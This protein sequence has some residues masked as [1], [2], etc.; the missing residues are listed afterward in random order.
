MTPPSSG[1]NSPGISPEAGDPLAAAGVLAYYL[2]ILPVPFL[3]AWTPACLA[4]QLRR[5]RERWRRRFRGPGLMACL[6]GSAVVA[7]YAASAFA[8]GVLGSGSAS[9]HTDRIYRAC[10]MGSLVAGLAI[11][12]CWFA[13]GT[14]G[15][16]RPCRQWSDRLG[17]L[18]GVCWTFVGAAGFVSIVLDW[19][20]PV[21]PIGPTARI[22]PQPRNKFLR[23]QAVK[24]S[25]AFQTGGRKRWSRLDDPSRI[26]DA[27]STMGHFRLPI[28]VSAIALGL[29]L[30]FGLAGVAMIVRSSLPGPERTV[31]AA[32]ARLGGGDVGG[33]S[34]RPVL[35][36]RGGQV[37][38]TPSDGE[39]CGTPRA[40][41]AVRR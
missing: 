36:G 5:P 23:A 17:R 34:G 16:L 10:A 41:E 39:G 2:S 32:A 7:G 15:V 4:M 14:C 9:D 30:A 12:S 26:R 13:M 11:L 38:Q 28:I 24:Y 8:W 35:A 25:D 1:R 40:V 6:V 19:T 22:D 31:P 37:G 18:T 27:P 33:G 3:A 20:D 29:A 21:G